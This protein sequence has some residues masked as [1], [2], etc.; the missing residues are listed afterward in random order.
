MNNKAL[1]E[2]ILARENYN[3]KEKEYIKLI[4][5]YCYNQIEN[6]RVKFNKN[7]MYVTFESWSYMSDKFMLKF[8]NEFGFLSPI[9]EFKELSETFTI[10]KFKFIKIID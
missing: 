6:T 2:L 4:E 8:C 7:K 1:S 9:I 10:Y 5:D 3:Q